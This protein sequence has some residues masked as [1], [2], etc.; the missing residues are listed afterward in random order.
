MFRTWIERREQQAKRMGRMMERLGVDVPQLASQRQGREFLQAM[1]TCAHCDS[2]EKCEQ[3]MADR[4]A[5]RPSSDPA[6]FCP[7][8]PRFAEC[9]GRK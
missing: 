7:N 4:Q 9:C 3:S 1:S 2:T 5:G 8:A 6:E